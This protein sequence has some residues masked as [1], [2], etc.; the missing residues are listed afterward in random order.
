[1]LETELFEIF[2]N[3]S[4]VGL[5]DTH[6]SGQRL[7]GKG[8]VTLRGGVLYDGAWEDGRMEG[9]GKITFPD[10]IEYEGDLKN[11]CIT[12][13]G[14]F[15]WPGSE[16]HGAVLNGKRYGK[17]HMRFYNSD[18]EYDGEW[19]AGMRHGHGTLKLNR[20]G[21]HRYEGQ[22]AHD[23]KQGQG[24]MHYSNGDVYTGQWEADLKCG[25]GH[26]F[27][28]RCDQEY[29]GQWANNMPNGVGSH[30]WFHQVTS[31][32]NTANHALLLM[33]NRYHGHFLDGKRSGYGVMYYATGARYEGLWLADKKQGLGCYVFENGD[34]WIGCFEEDRPVLQEGE[35]FAPRSSNISISIEDLVLEEEAP[36][37][38]LKGIGNVMMV[39]NSDLRSLY[40]KY[41]K[42]P[43]L[44]MELNTP[45]NTSHA[46]RTAQFWELLS[47]ARLVSSSTPVSK[48]G[49]LLILSRR[50]SE[51]LYKTRLEM[52]AEL[53]VPGDMEDERFWSQ[54][55]DEHVLGG[56][57]NPTAEVLFPAF[58][59]VLARLAAIR[60]RSL[61]GVERRLDTMIKVHL[62]G[63]VAP[64]K[65]NSPP[66]LSPMHA[67]LWSSE[68]TLKLLQEH[69]PQLNLLFA[70]AAGITLISDGGVGGEASSSLHVYQM[71]S[72]VRKVLNLLLEMGML[73][74][75]AAV[76]S[77]ARAMCHNYLQA[78]LFSNAQRSRQDEGVIES[79]TESG[80]AGETFSSESEDLEVLAWMD[81]PVIYPEFIEGIVRIA[82]DSVPSDPASSNLYRRLKDLLS[83]IISRLPQS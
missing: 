45:H 38:A 70:K 59:E 5:S 58:C 76:A 7:Q 83:A 3:A 12:G 20:D 79:A 10:G 50:P 37:A 30:I 67:E 39:F 33:Y 6:A 68:Q 65:A 41:C 4:D 48:A 23:M 32:P 64:S 40:D 8:V 66:P 29:K 25:H 24:I 17:G 21:T 31:E 1:M 72:T 81:M 44:H 11:S 27:W 56:V 49:E 57:H 74:D 63:L 19:A 46:L 75:A 42:R 69:R 47:D 71:E 2:I 82:Y 80:A 22:W 51:V 78:N 73:P 54:L 55:I 62:L 36:T 15:K 28:K 77:A 16:Y 53:H 52:E 9:Q 34:I 43:S 61:P 60:Y 14:V 26:M 18:C 35:Q 13:V